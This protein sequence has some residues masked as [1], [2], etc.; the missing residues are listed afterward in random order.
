M[1]PD[2]SFSDLYLEEV[3]KGAMSPN[4]YDLGRPRLWVRTELERRVADDRRTLRLFFLKRT[5]LTQSN[6]QTV[7]IVIP[8]DPDTGILL[9]ESELLDNVRK[10]VKR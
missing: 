9:A 10:L 5:E 7:Q 3:L 8:T 4:R 6:R 2:G 1:G